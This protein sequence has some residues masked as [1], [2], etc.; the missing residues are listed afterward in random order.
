[1]TLPRGE[2]YHYDVTIEP[3]C[4]KR[5]NRIVFEEVIRRNK[6]YDVAKFKPVFDGSKNM[7]TRGKLPIPEGKVF[8]FD[9]LVS[10]EEGDKAR[11]FKVK[12]QLAARIDLEC[13]EACLKD[14]SERMQALQALDVVMRHSA[15]MRF[16]P[17][18]RSFFTPPQGDPF[19]LGEG[20]VVWSGY[21]N[22]LRPT[23]KW[24]MVL[25][26][27]VSNTAFYQEGPVLDFMKEVLVSSQF[28]PFRGDPPRDRE[29]VQ[30]AKEI[31]G[32]KVVVT[33]LP[34]PR[35]YRVV[36]VTRESASRQTFPL[37]GKRCTVQQYFRDAHKKE[38][39]FP[40]LPCLHV[41]Q[42]EK[43]V[44]IPIELC[45]IVPGQKC[46]K[47]LTERQTSQ[48]V[49][50]SAK[51]AHVRQKDIM[52]KFA[53]AD[54]ENDRHMN[55]FGM[56]VERRMVQ[57]TGRVLPAPVLEYLGARVTPD[58]GVWNMNRER[59]HE[60][61][62][63]REWVV[64]VFERYCR[65][66]KVR[67]FMERLH[68]KGNAMGM[69]I[70]QGPL[71]VTYYDP[72]RNGSVEKCFEGLRSRYPGL[73]LVIAVLGRRGITYGEVKRTGDTMVGLKT[74]CV[75]SDTIDKKCNA[76][77]LSNLCLK[78]NAKLGGVNN[79]FDTSL[80]QVF[81]E[82]P[83]IVMGADVTHP[84][85]GDDKKPSIA[86]LV[87]SMDSNACVY[88]ADARVQKHRKE[89]IVDM[90]EMVLDMLRA[91]YAANR[92][93]KPHRI[94]FYRDGVSEG[95][96]KQVIEEEVS[97]IQAACMRLEKGYEPGITFL[98]VQKRHHVRFFPTN[99]DDGV[100][101]AGNVP[102]GTIV[103]RDITH[104]TEYDFYLCSHVGIQGTSRP[105]H[106]HV[107]RDDN[108]FSPDELEQLSYR[109]C[110]VF[111]RCNRSVSY[112][113]PAYYAHLAAFRARHILHD[114]E[115]SGSEDSA[116]AYSARSDAQHS[117]AEMAQA[118]KTH[119]RVKYTMY[120]A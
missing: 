68:E 5:V 9:G 26:L 105:C 107:L 103:D 101:K 60:G 56:R 20:R 84:S 31:K 8:Q 120:F 73:Q 39:E 83:V 22:S 16:V 66:D 37:D 61:A 116:S 110:H 69:H 1:M 104:P 99:R 90:E 92:Q 50:Q 23:T 86:A 72:R 32:L 2:I 40:N 106:Y 108:N 58:K 48:M 111:F 76:A 78:I 89:I 114:W 118:I 93:A 57:V 64:V 55:D 18:G 21:Y 94:I 98:V 15:S 42:K 71:E 33:H 43:H 77:T 49:R 4:P 13:L 91:F 17:V 3:K 54:F 30:F 85:P 70:R 96:F 35:K 29:R 65:E 47:K 74:Q 6:K 51:P 79:T 87:A 113:A 80:L 63:I 24:K 38:L 109:L 44:Y 62:E 14:A 102:P 95:Q 82:G 119:E 34:Y 81:K 36:D 100:G 75:M 117:Q 53:S 11:E 112:P 46:A 28:D 25:N 41:G 115:A 59:F 97:A 52:E 67:S 19:Y 45:E 7:Y 10:V 27:D 88:R 12:V